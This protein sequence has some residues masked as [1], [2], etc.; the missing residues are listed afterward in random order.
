MMASGATPNPSPGSPPRMVSAWIECEPVGR[1]AWLVHAREEAAKGYPI[2][3]FVSAIDEIPKGRA[4]LPWA[5]DRASLHLVLTVWMRELHDQLEHHGGSVPV[6]HEE[7]LLAAIDE[8]LRLH[9]AVVR[10]PGGTRRGRL[11]T[12]AGD[13]RADPFSGPAITPVT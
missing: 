5:A 12:E 2:G 9:L 13:N 1:L 11:T 7:D 4:Q 3:P 8:G 10:R 6:P